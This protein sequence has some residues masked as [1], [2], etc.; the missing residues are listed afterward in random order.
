MREEQ[1]TFITDGEVQIVGERPEIWQ[2]SSEE[3]SIFLSLSA[4]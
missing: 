4:R 3:E 2:E 1:K